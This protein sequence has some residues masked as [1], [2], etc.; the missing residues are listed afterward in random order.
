MPE[1]AIHIVKS[2]LNPHLTQL[3]PVLHGIIKENFAALLPTSSD[4]TPVL[5]YENIV[6]VVATASARLFA[7]EEAS[8]DRNWV[9]NGIA[10]TNDAV[11]YAQALKMWPPVLRPFVYRFVP[12]YRTVQKQLK[13]CR[14]IVQK[15]VLRYKREVADGTFDET[16]G[17]MISWIHQEAPPQLANDLSFHFRTQMALTIASLHTTSTTT[18]QCLYDLAA[19]PEL[20]PVLRAEVKEH[21]AANNGEGFTRPMLNKLWKLDSFMKESQRWSSPDLTTFQR[22][23]VRSFT[24]SDGLR[25][26][27][28]TKL[29]MATAAVYQDPEVVPN[30]ASWDALRYYNQR[31]SLDEQNSGPTAKSAPTSMENNQAKHQF[32]TV[33]KESLSFGFGKHACPG[34]FL[35]DIEV[36][37]ML[38]EILLNY[39]LKNP[40]GQKERHAN[41]EFENLVFPDASK[42]ILLRRIS[43]RK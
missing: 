24:L 30:P 9:E 20:I 29:E 18:T 36:K 10:F 8:R 17:N 5:F 28:N 25:I 39:D 1:L 23:S 27:A 16:L 15:N 12:G 2:K 21:L 3:T 19:H 13:A 42:S 43:A 31:K 7:G 32:V 34:R 4:W 6:N 37:L 35:A 33:T 14:V 40:D 41:V 38:C 22:R 11:N 26:P